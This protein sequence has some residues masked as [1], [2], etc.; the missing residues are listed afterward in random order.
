MQVI[1]TGKE[2]FYQVREELPH[3]GMAELNLET[4]PLYKLTITD[5]QD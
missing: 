2:K 3:G 1:L 5:K 4:S